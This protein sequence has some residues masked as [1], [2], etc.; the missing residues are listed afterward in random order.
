MWE[1]VERGWEFQLELVVGL[2]G[3]HSTAYRLQRKMEVLE[4]VVAFVFG[5]G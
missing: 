1:V 2:T 3:G 4:G 5:V